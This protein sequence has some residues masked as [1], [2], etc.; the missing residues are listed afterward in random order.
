MLRLSGLPLQRVLGPPLPA[1]MR[2][3][4]AP[5][6]TAVMRTTLRGVGAPSASRAG[7]GG[8]PITSSARLCRLFSGSTPST[9]APRRSAR[10]ARPRP[11]FRHRG[12]LSI[13]TASGRRTRTTTTT[14]RNVGRKSRMSLLRTL[15]TGCVPTMPALSSRALVACD[16][17]GGC[18]RVPPTSSAT[19]SVRCTPARY[20]QSSTCTIRNWVMNLTS[21]REILCA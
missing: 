20:P 11:K 14:R 6:G 7:P 4:T 5:T 15:W 13:Q 17:W 1:Q 8:S 3:A 18:L 9:A 12:R 19:S 2:A 16:M 10:R 21:N